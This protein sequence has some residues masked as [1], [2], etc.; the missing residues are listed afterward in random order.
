MVDLSEL[1]KDFPS[2]ESK[3]LEIHR[4][5][6]VVRRNNDK[7]KGVQGAAKKLRE[8]NRQLREVNADLRKRLRAASG[9]TPDLFDQLFGR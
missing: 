7:G 2:E 5:R 6:G 9:P 8:E 1:R 3:L 4:L